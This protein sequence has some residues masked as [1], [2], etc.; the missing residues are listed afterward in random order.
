M[1]GTR[2]TG[3]WKN[4]SKDGK[5]TYLAGNLGVARI[6]ILANDFKEKDNE[7]DY[8]LFVVPKENGKAKDEDSQKDDVP[9]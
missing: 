3:L 9:L 2:L 4:Q 5:K 8:N 7:P 1:N 6:L